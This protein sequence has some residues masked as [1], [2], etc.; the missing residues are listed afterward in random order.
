MAKRPSPTKMSKSRVTTKEDP[1]GRRAKAPARAHRDDTP[2]ARD[3][4][5]RV[6]K[7]HPTRATSAARKDK[8]R[9]TR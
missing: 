2:E 7:T 1:G 8:T 5:R 4:R 9:P 6:A 3:Q